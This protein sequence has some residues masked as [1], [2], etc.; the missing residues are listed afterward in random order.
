ME[1]KWSVV[2]NG[3]RND[4]RSYVRV[5]NFIFYINKILSE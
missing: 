4:R 5:E 3:L 1:Y 2:E